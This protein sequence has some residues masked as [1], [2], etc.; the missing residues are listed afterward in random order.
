M[1]VNVRVHNGDAHRA[2]GRCSINSRPRSSLGCPQISSSP[3][4]LL[5][6][7][8]CLLRPLPTLAT[9]QPSAAL[10]SIVRSFCVL[11]DVACTC[12][13]SRGVGVLSHIPRAIRMPKPQPAAAVGSGQ[14]CDSTVLQSGGQQRAAQRCGQEAAGNAGPLL[15]LVP[16]RRWRAAKRPITCRG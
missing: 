4:I 11:L 14:V 6:P 16:A 12:A 3:E 1:M 2:H 7:P 15:M 13:I 9:T 10:S 5:P 8:E